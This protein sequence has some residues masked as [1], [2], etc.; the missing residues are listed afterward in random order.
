MAIVVRFEGRTDMG[1]LRRRNEDA[2]GVAA[3]PEGDGG[4]L[5]VVADGMGG[6]P[7]G[8]IASRTAVEAALESVRRE[9]GRQT[10]PERLASAFEDARERLRSQILLRPDL[11]AMGT[12]L[13]ALLVQDDGAWVGSIGDSRL[14]WQRGRVLRLVT[15][16]HNAAWRLVADGTLDA[17]E[18]ERSPEGARLTRFL[19]PVLEFEP[20]IP[21]QPLR[22]LPGDRLLLCSDGLGK[23]LRMSRIAAVLADGSIAEA[24]VRAVDRT[25]REGAPDNVTVLLAEIVEAPLPMGETIEWESLRY[26]WEADPGASH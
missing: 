22:I 21:S 18:A 20:D 26:A 14:L 25:L 24:V 8:D 17:D 13:T 3:I 19:N 4:F 5:F 2:W 9:R 1:L 15:E 23:A 10:G 16:D 7:G 11:E 12:T 6:H